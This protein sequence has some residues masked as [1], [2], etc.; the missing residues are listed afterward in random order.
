MANLCIAGKL[1]ICMVGR[2]RGDLLVQASKQAGAHGGTV[3]LGRTVNDSRVLQILALADVYQD[4]VFTLLGSEYDQVLKALQAAA[5]E[6]KKLSGVA[7]LVDVAAIFVRGTAK[8]SQAGCSQTGQAESQAGQGQINARREN[9]DSGYELITAIVNYGYADDVMAV[10]RKAGAQGGTIFNARGTGTEDDV[11][12]FG[13]SLV[14]EKEMLFIVA[15]K[16]KVQGIID[17][18]NNIPFLCK[19]GG[20]IVFNMNVEQFVV[21]GNEAKAC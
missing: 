1:L 4:I 12:F 6:N 10:A 20:G 19:P 13:I 15:A 11:K 3:A 8:E 16:E 17:A 7:I 14:P 9:M 2:H 5:C 18:V 21:L